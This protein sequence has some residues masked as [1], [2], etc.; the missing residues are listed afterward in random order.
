MQYKYVVLTNTTIGTFM[1][2]LDSNIVLISLPPTIRHV[3]GTTTIEGIWIS[4]G[5][6]LVTAGLLMTIGRLAD[7]YGRVRL[8]NLGFA[9]FT[10]G[11]GLCSLSPNGQSLVL[12][13]LV[14]GIGAGL[15]V[16]NGAA[17]VTDAFPVA[18][19]GRARGLNQVA[20]TGGALIGLVAGGV[21]TAYL[22]WQSI[23]WINVPVGVFA[24]VWAYTRL[25]ELGR[26]P[27][28]ENLD[29][30]GNLLFA[31]G[32]S[33]ALLGV[34]LGAI[35]GWATIDLIMLFAGVA[36]LVA[37]VPIERV[38]P[39]PMMDL[40]LFRNGVFSAGVLSNLL[41]S[42]A[43]GAVGLVLVFYFQGALGLDAL[44]A[45]V[46]L[47][48]FSLAFVSIGP[49]SGY[50]SDKYGPRGFTTAGLLI[51]GASYV[52]FATL[53]YRASYSILVLPMILAGIGG[54]LFIAPN[55]AS[56]MNSVPVVRRGVAAGM[57]S[58]LFNVGFLTSLGLSFAIM[59]SRMPLPV[60]QAIFAGLPVPQGQLEIGAFMEAFHQIFYVIAA[61]SL[62]GAILRAGSPP[63]IDDSPPRLRR[64]GR[65][66]RRSRGNHGRKRDS[67]GPRG[68]GR[69]GTR[70]HP[71][72]ND[73]SPVARLHRLDQLANRPGPAAAAV[74]P[75][76]A[77]RRPGRPAVPLM[78]RPRWNSRGPR[79]PRFRSQCDRR[80]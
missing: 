51:S 67:E 8:Y 73:R 35:S 20:G 77:V 16:P 66:D 65:R 61:I 49:I 3:P 45:G 18:E 41:A 23:F 74:K 28:R 44:T 71:Q 40:A 14:Q 64:R 22:G 42:T 26:H 76:V 69:P 2:L 80:A 21:L 1:A 70:R 57:S 15:L 62:I 38:V 27:G 6:V 10:I 11:S 60:M 24:T 34:T 58:T 75:S 55:V 29:P 5:S 30:A 63:G 59:A 72:S 17:I 4:V 50:L 9:V 19:R 52:W 53:P 37:F 78:A 36:C 7:L 33:L 32:L 12:F 79:S 56:I 13:R 43:R 46:L 48:P 47:I 39:S 54:G 68:K 25:K 31:G